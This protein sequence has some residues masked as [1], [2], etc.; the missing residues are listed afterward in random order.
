[1]IVGLTNEA[2]TCPTG[3]PL[4]ASCSAAISAACHP[5]LDDTDAAFEKVRCGDVGIKNSV[6]HCTFTSYSVTTPIAGQTY[7]E[8]RSCLNEESWEAIEE[9]V[10]WTKTFR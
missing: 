2:W 8:M 7:A 6:R 10:A 5:P 3:I 9:E 4:A 1:M